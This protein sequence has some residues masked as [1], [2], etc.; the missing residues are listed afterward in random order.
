MAS[1]GVGL[2]AQLGAEFWA[3]VLHFIGEFALMAYA[4]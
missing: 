4:N 3:L 2:T 1:I